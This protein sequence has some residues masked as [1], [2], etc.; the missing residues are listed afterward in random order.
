MGWAMNAVGLLI[1][2]LMKSGKIRYF[3]VLRF[4]IFWL[5]L[6]SYVRVLLGQCLQYQALIVDSMLFDPLYTVMVVFSVCL[7][8]QTMLC[9]GPVECFYTINLP[10]HLGL[11]DPSAFI[12]DVP[13]SEAPFCTL[14]PTAH[15]LPKPLKFALARKMLIF[16]IYQKSL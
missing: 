7:P 1:F 6:T 13:L 5:N 12:Y 9:P 14:V 2:G 4:A 11:Y 3:P 16:T 10:Q 15:I 8:K